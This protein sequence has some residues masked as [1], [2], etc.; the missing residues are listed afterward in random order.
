MRHGVHRV[1]GS[2]A[3]RSAAI[4]ALAGALATGCAVDADNGTTGEDEV[5]QDESAIISGTPVTSGDFGPVE[6]FFLGR[7]SGTLLTN[8]WV[9]TA[10]HCVGP[11]TETSP[12]LVDVKTPTQVR[13]AKKVVR[14]VA[15][16]TALIKVD[17]L[18]IR[19]STVG[20]LQPTWTWDVSLLT[21][22]WVQCY[23]YGVNVQ[24]PGTMGTG[25]GVLRT[26][27]LQV[28]S[29]APDKIVIAPDVYGRRLAYG[30]SG[31][32]CFV[33]ALA[34]TEPFLIG[35]AYKGDAAAG[36]VKPYGRVLDLVARAI[37]QDSQSAPI[38]SGLEL[39]R[40]VTPDVSKWLV[41]R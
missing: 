3:A 13:K 40:P 35:H 27:I 26:A 25:D 41:F 10:A 21:N 5:A 8:S 31:G 29:A 20:F 14:F 4:A 22:Q 23:G 7:C 33:T 28:A 36:W 18:S 32:P 30:D 12:S 1:F 37:F 39:Q 34:G 24:L 16:D 17:P 2:V 38:W 11:E 9:L 15:E 19:G 6:V